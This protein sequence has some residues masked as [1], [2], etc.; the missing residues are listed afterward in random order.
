MRSALAKVLSVDRDGGATGR[1]V[2]PVSPKDSPAV[3]GP[4]NLSEVVPRKPGAVQGDLGRRGEEL[5]FSGAR[6]LSEG[7]KV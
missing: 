3:R 7:E 4:H 6:R 2:S 1:A 5:S